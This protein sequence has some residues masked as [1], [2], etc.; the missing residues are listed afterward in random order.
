M[1]AEIIL[2]FEKYKEGRRTT[3]RGMVTFANK[4]TKL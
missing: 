4:I 1:L 2:D 3:E